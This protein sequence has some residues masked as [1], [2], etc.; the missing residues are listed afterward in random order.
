MRLFTLAA[1]LL[2]NTPTLAVDAVTYKGTLGKSHIVVELT[3]LT[4][5]KMVGR[6]SY[7]S[8]GGDIPLHHTDSISGFAFAEEAPCTQDT[9]IADENGTIAD[10]PLGA[11]WTLA[12]TSDGMGLAGQWKPASGDGKVLNVTLAEIGRRTLPEGTELSAMGLAD[13]AFIGIHAYGVPV[14][15]TTQPYEF[16]K[17]GVSLS[18]GDLQD[19]DG[20]T[21]RFVSDPRSLFGF[22]RVVSLADGSSPDA[23]NHALSARHAAINVAAFSC[24]NSAYAGFSYSPYDINMEGGSLGDYDGES[25]AVGYLSPTI[26][27]WTE[28]GS[29]W[30][31]GAHPNNHFNSFILDVRTGETLALGKVFKHWTAIR[32]IDADEPGD[33]PIDQTEALAD[34]DRYS[35]AAGQPLIDYVLAHYQGEPVEGC[36]FEDLITTNLGV[37]FG[38]GDTAIF[39]LADLPHAVSACAE[40][41]LTVKLAN[42]PQL[43]APTAKDYFPGLAK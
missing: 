12:F 7:L 10:S 11:H 35:W 22:P 27:G 5:G 21:F 43:L 6:Y 8:I 2:A 33:E 39:S 34:P 15:A 1:A 23:I 24:L 4:H 28:A 42:I 30:C 26:M 37:R 31:G 9:C 16:A 17:M 41:V 18:D 36:E 14:T 20:S 29:T 38:Q 40:D 13:S 32:R 3:D 25:I 19:L